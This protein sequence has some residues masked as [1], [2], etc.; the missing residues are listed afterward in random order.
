MKRAARALGVCAGLCLLGANALGQDAAPRASADAGAA[1]TSAQDPE[2]PEHLKPRT[3]ISV[4]PNQGLS[5]GD[6][7]TLKIEATVKKGVQLSVPDQSLAPFEALARRSTVED[8]GAEQRF[9]FELDLMALEPGELTIPALTLRAVA[10]DGSLAEV[11]LDPQPVSVKSLIAN[12]PN[13]EPK[14]PTKPVTV[15]QDDYTLA[16]VGLG[17]LGIAAIAGLTLLIQRWL[18]RRP[19]PVPPPPPARPAWEVALGKLAELDA[20]KAALLAEDRGEEFIDGVSD[21]LREYL[22][23]RYGFEGLESTTD[24]VLRALERI[25]PHKLSLSGVSLLLEQCDLVKFA[26][27]KPDATQCDDLWNGAVGLIRATTPA[28]E[29]ANAPGAKP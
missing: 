18:A 6:P 23:K 11:K 28:P 5:V 13:A 10:D 16:Y 3:L 27:F 29:P 17:I 8:K 22:G 9:V 14:P 4:T 2:V 12:E 21:A 24:E 19:K 1:V 26:R 25:R 7:I 20:R 15:I